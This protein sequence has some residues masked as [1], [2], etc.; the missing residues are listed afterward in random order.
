[1]EN[2]DIFLMASDSRIQE[3]LDQESMLVPGL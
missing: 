2:M 3:S 1:M